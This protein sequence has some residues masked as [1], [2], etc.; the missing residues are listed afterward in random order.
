M[1]PE[2]L[3]LF[4]IKATKFQKT[5]HMARSL[6]KLFFITLSK[7]NPHWNNMETEWK[8]MAQSTKI[9]TTILRKCWMRR[10]PIRQTPSGNK[11]KKRRRKF[12][13]STKNL[14]SIFSQVRVSLCSPSIWDTPQAEA[15]V[16]IET[17]YSESANSGD[18]AFFFRQENRW[19]E[20]GW[21]WG[22]EINKNSSE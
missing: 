14:I 5:I 21:F 15:K 1:Q 8:P 11:R 20:F 9:V 7:H 16:K 10:G 19:R 2:V 6:G 17:T 3:S 22:T 13:T 4:L 12:L 18:K